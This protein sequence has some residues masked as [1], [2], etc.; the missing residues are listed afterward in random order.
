MIQDNK[1]AY[2]LNEFLLSKSSL[3]QLGLKLAY[4]HYWFSLKV[5][6]YFL[7]IAEAAL[8]ILMMTNVYS[9]EVIFA[10]S[11][12]QFARDSSDYWGPLCNLLLLIDGVPLALF[13]LAQ[14][15][16][17]SQTW[18]F[19]M[20]EQKNYIRPFSKLK[21]MF[22]Y[23]AVHVVL[24]LCL[25]TSLVLSVLL[26]VFMGGADDLS[27]LPE[28]STLGIN[29]FTGFMTCFLSCHLIWSHDEAGVAALK[30]CRRMFFN[31]LI[32]CLGSGALLLANYLAMRGH[33]IMPWPEAITL[34]LLSFLLFTHYSY[35]SKLV[36]IY[37]QSFI[38]GMYIMA[39]TALAAN[40]LFQSEMISLDRVYILSCAVVVL[41]VAMSL[42]YRL[43][44][45]RQRSLQIDALKQVEQQKNVLIVDA[46][47]SGDAMVVA[48]LLALGANVHQRTATGDQ[49]LHLAVKH[50]RLAVVKQLLRFGADVNVENKMR[51]NSLHIAASRA[52][53]AILKLLLNSGA[54][55]T[56]RDIHGKNPLHRLCSHT[57]TA[58][59]LDKERVDSVRQLLKL[60]V[61]P[62]EPD[63]LGMTAYE[64]AKKRKIQKVIELMDAHAVNATS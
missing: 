43:I 52:N 54:R 18:V 6:L 34:L 14:F 60:G 51:A 17:F 62:F 2:R 22:S 21:Q 37:G 56:A 46:V 64:N 59:H 16:T 39:L 4:P 31:P 5:L 36:G 61:D 13:M 63:N 25:N 50:D 1:A 8:I 29:T 26:L 7:L 11:L 15:G 49:L 19:K 38:I 20:V 58:A 53:F 9:S 12:N 3:Y 45:C 57:L 28:Y 35:G 33:E 41:I 32:G 27:L 23:P 47:T 44:A 48:G 55:C 40:M 42:H 10:D 24:V 30:R